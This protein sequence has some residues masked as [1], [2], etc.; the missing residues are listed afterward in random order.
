VDWTTTPGMEASLTLPASE[1]T[2]GKVASVRFELGDSGL[3][4]VGT[5]GLI[6][7]HPGTIDALVG[8]IDGLVGTIDALA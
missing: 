5:R 6:D 3:M 8:T 4:D 2:R 1:Q 7:I